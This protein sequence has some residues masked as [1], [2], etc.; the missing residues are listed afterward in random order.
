MHRPKCCVY[1]HTKI[2]EDEGQKHWAFAS[3][4][5]LLLMRSLVKLLP[6]PWDAEM[7]SILDNLLALR[8]LELCSP[9]D[10]FV[11]NSRLPEL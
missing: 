1:E 8:G 4:L 6:S 11:R 7:F 9:K 2:R 3:L 10:R 5:L